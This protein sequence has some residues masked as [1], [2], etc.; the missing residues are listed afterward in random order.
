MNINEI[1]KMAD[2]IA[3]QLEEVRGP[4]ARKDIVVN[5]LVHFRYLVLEGV[6]M[7]IKQAIKAVKLA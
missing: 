4:E 6:E 2:R 1:C 7:Y 3:K 5:E